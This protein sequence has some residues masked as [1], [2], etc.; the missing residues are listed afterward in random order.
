MHYHAG[1]QHAGAVL[2]VLLLCL[3]ATL[4]SEPDPFAPGAHACFG[5]MA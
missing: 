3:S 1:R 4:A 5:T 2:L